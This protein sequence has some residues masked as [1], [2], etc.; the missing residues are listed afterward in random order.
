MNNKGQSKLDTV[1]KMLLI[2]FISLLAFSSGVYFGHEMSLSQH[3]LKTLEADFEH[4]K[5]EGTGTSIAEEDVDA[6]ANKYVNNEKE[7]I[8]DEEPAGEHGGSEH[9]TAAA[10]HGTASE[11]GSGAKEQIVTEGPAKASDSHGA[12]AH[13]SAKEVDEEPIA[14]AHD[15][16]AH[17]GASEKKEESKESAANS[18]YKAHQVKVEDVKPI[19]AERKIAAASEPDHAAVFRAAQRV[20]HDSAPTAEPAKAAASRQPTSLPTQIGSGANFP[21]T[22]QIASYLTKEDAKSHIDELIKKGYP[23]YIVEAQVKG[24]TRYRVSVGNFAT[25][26]EAGDYRA[27]LVKQADLQSAIVQKIER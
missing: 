9:G 13:G 8:V 11:H 17:H 4:K 18:T 14:K 3:S 2:A 6:M 1:L 24:A 22:V 5:A 10:G 26:K 21:Y 19:K 27:T 7:K 23:A 15:E 12:V 16:P 20:A 25:Q